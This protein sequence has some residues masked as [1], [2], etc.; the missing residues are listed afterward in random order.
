MFVFHKRRMV[1][2]QADG[3]ADGGQ[4]PPIET[5]PVV[6]REPQTPP[7]SLPET[8]EELRA[9]VKKLE[10][11]KAAVIRESMG[12]KTKLQELETAKQAALD[13]AKAAADQKL[14]DEGKSAEVAMAA[15]A[16][17]DVA[18]AERDTYAAKVS[19]ANEL[20]SA[21]IEKRIKD[22]PDEAK[23]LL[24][25]GEGVDAL[26]RLEQVAKVEPLANKLMDVPARPGNGSGPT[27]TGGPAPAN[28]KALAE[29][30][31]ESTRR[32]F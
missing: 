18:I 15:Q 28:E 29:A 2:F 17:R 16:E 22:W 12:R 31:M 7:D 19:K 9:L 13:A 3:A 10:D 21:D 14:I 27:A 20:L 5:P 6:P 23:A 32:S 4:A 24:S 8:P 26:E 1:L 30:A 11:E 25:D